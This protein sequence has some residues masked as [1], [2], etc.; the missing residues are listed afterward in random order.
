MIN[1]VH[2]M[3]GAEKEISKAGIVPEYEDLLL[4]D[5]GKAPALNHSMTE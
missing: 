1:G 4:K 3:I 2:A 5:K